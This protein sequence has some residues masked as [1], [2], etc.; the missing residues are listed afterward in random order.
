MNMI[1]MGL[2]DKFHNVNVK[3]DLNKTLPANYGRE[4][5]AYNPQAY[6]TQQAG[7]NNIFANLNALKQPADWQKI[8]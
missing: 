4:N 5:F 1:G 6:A 3:K 8:K 7:A 2:K